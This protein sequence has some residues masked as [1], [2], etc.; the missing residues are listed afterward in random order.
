MNLFEELTL[1]EIELFESI[2]GVA[3]DEIGNAN[4]PKGKIW[5]AL[6]FVWAKRSNPEITL[7]SI[8]AMTRAQADK[9][10]ESVT[11]PK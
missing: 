6:T 7:D 9:L 10:L 2:S 1:A 8:K 5:Q 3:I 4:Q 11:D